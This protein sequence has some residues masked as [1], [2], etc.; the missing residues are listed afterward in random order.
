MTTQA[1]HSYDGN[2]MHV[3]IQPQTL[4]VHRQKTKKWKAQ[5]NNALMWQ[6]DSGTLCIRLIITDTSW[7]KRVLVQAVH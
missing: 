6:C 4:T 1:Q 5:Q 7:V 3:L 2:F